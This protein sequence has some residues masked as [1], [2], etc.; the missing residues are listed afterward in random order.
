MSGTPVFYSENLLFSF[1]FYSFFYSVVL[2]TLLS[3]NVAKIRIKAEY[4]T[5]KRKSMINCDKQNLI[6]SIENSINFIGS[7]LDSANKTI[8]YILR[9]HGVRDLKKESIHTLQDL[10]NELYAIEADLC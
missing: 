5:R 10:F 4:T 9:K 7:H 3:I 1:F 8:A 2:S 6:I